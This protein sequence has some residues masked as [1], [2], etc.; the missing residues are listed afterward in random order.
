MIRNIKDTVTINELEWYE[1]SLDF[2]CYLCDSHS[3]KNFHLSKDKNLLFVVCE[4][5]LKKAKEKI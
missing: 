5:C 2:P 4:E 3:Y 1:G